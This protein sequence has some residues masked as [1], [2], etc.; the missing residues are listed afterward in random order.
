MTEMCCLSKQFTVYV[1]SV[2][3]LYFVC[4]Q[5]LI[6][7]LYANALIIKSI[8]VRLWVF[9][10]HLQD[11]IMIEIANLIILT[12]VIRKSSSLKHLSN[13]LQVRWPLVCI[14]QRKD[15]FYL[16]STDLLEAMGK[17]IQLFAFVYRFKI[18]IDSIKSKSIS[19]ISNPRLNNFQGSVLDLK[20]NETQ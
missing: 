6:N 4:K 12:L 7:I 2:S 18:L 16:Y 20:T 5:R 10:A 11:Q 8:F 3:T 9:I 13:L 1:Y 14:I 19:Y 17:R 15:N